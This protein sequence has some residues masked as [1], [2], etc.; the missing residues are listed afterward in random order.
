M[1][2]TA[3]FGKDRKCVTPSI[4]A[5]RATVTGLT[6]RPEIVGHKLYKDSFTPPVLFDNLHTK[7]KIDVV[8]LDQMKEGC[9]QNLD[10][11]Y[12]CSKVT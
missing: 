6:G 11:Q 8:L 1:Y 9:I 5:T 7:Q 4:A 12:N 10:R 2:K 3:Y